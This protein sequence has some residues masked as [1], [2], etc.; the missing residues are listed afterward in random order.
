MPA[1]H[2]FLVDLLGCITLPIFLILA[3]GVMTGARVD[4]LITGLLSAVGAVIKVLF[5]ILGMMFTGLIGETGKT[6]ANSQKSR[7]VSSHPGGGKRRTPKIKFVVE[8][9]DSHVWK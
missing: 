1:E 4:G 3:F 7:S 2:N 8:E 9:D 6:I 5:Q